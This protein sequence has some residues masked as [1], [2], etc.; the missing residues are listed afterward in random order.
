M[1]ESGN[2]NSEA[3]REELNGTT[4]EMR[5]ICGMHRSIQISDIMRLQKDTWGAFTKSETP[6]LLTEEENIRADDKLTSLV[7][8]LLPQA[9]VSFIQLAHA[10]GKPHL[11]SMISQLT[12][13]VGRPSHFAEYLLSINQLPQDEYIW[14]PI[15]TQKGEEPYIQV[16]PT[17]LKCGRYPEMLTNQSETNIDFI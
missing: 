3:R 9:E 14:L 4:P 8:R 1:D 17:F 6:N 2:A 15:R 5:K 12:E 13:K 16:A 11:A 10:H 7:H